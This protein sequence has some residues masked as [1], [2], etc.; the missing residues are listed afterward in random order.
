MSKS[1]LVILEVQG[2]LGHFNKNLASL[3]IPIGKNY[4]N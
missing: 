2:Y 4:E 3:P 1:I